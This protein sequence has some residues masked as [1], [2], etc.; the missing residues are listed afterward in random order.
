M[1]VVVGLLSQAVAAPMSAEE[2]HERYWTLTDVRDHVIRGELD[3]AKTI[4]SALKELPSKRTPRRWRSYLTA[5]DNALEAVATSDDLDAAAMGVGKAAST[6]GS[7]HSATG[8][9][10]QLVGAA[11]VPPPKWEPD[12]QM[13]LHRWAM[14][15]MW[16]G[17]LDQNGDAWRLGA[18]ELDRKPL[19]FRSTDD[20]SVFEG[21]T[22]LEDRVHE[23]AEYATTTD[24]DQR[25]DVFGILLATCSDCHAEM[26]AAKEAAS[27]ESADSEPTVDGPG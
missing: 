8:G 3:Q 23:L 18:S 11:N 2:M 16:L 26:T 19:V 21:R 13:A 14:D 22:A 27:A 1:L 9:G 4:A 6:C 24:S 7:C 12:Q 25:G 17:L 15:W 20:D 5:V 10:P